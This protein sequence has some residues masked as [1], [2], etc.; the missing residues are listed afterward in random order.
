[1]MM[2]QAQLDLLRRMAIQAQQADM[3]VG[4]GA[5]VL[6]ALIDEIEQLRERLKGIEDRTVAHVRE[7]IWGDP[8][9]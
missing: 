8:R 1:M 4:L 6:L 2:T 5:N 3:D 9:T 7:A